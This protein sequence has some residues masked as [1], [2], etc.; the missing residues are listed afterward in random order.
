MPFS[1]SVANP[2][3]VGGLPD[4]SGDGVRPSGPPGG[5]SSEPPLPPRSSFPPGAREAALVVLPSP[6]S[7]VSA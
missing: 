4:A 2:S 1:A 3:S 5:P 7:F 6:S